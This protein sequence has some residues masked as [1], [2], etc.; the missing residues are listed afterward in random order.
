MAIYRKYT[1]WGRLIDIGEGETYCP[2]CNGKGCKIGTIS[3]GAIIKIPCGF[4]QGYGK[5]DWIQTATN[6]PRIAPAPEEYINHLQNNFMEFTSLWLAKRIDK[7]I[8]DSLT[9]SGQARSLMSYDL[10]K[11][12]AMS[13]KATV[14]TATQA[15][16]KDSFKCVQDV[17]ATDIVIGLT[18]QRAP[19]T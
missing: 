7:E 15:K 6:E 10:M 11:R 2:K 5:T 9:T 18:G 16:V 19:L 12:Y 4:C 3:N 8:L 1:E 14:V 17:R 13:A